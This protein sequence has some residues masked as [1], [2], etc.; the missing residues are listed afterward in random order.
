MSID[1]L[2]SPHKNTRGLPAEDADSDY[3]GI[4]RTEELVII[5]ITWNEGRST[6][7]KQALYNAIVDD[8]HSAVGL[9]REDVF[10]QPY[11]GQERK[12]VFR[13]R[14]SLV[15]ALGLG[16]LLPGVEDGVDVLCYLP[17]SIE[18]SLALRR[19]KTQ[20]RSNQASSG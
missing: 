6:S 7:Q 5:Q 19:G 20:L 13:Q 10:D 8:L 14:R 17:Y 18:Y 11:R 3:I 1:L 15:R 2:G 9:R 12:L 16:S 4:H